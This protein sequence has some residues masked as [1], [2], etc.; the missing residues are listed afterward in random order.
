MREA[1]S[2]DERDAEAEL[3]DVLDD[4]HH[5]QV[6]S[7]RL[8]TEAMSGGYNSTFRGSGVEFDEV[9]EYVDG[10]DPRAVD[11]NVTARFGRLFVKRFVDERELSLLFLLDISASMDGGF[12]AWSLRQFATR[13]CACLSFAAVQNGDNIGLVA[14]HNEVASYLKPKKGVAQA[15]RII[16]TSL[17]LPFQASDC[18]LTTGLDFVARNVRRRTVLFVV[19]DFLSEG[20]EKSMGKNAAKHDVVALRL[21]PPELETLPQGPLRLFDPETGRDFIFDNSNESLRR[22]YQD[23][24]AKWRRGCDAA[25]RR[26]HADVVDLSL[27]RD[28]DP[29]AA[30][31]PILE[32]FRRREMGRGRQ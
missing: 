2:Q 1:K 20:W 28:P 4:V 25:L 30:A 12:A 14:A 15:L 31:K 11:W 9:R 10:D 19:S 5:I 27:P 21:L 24:V 22:S 23:R 16:R 18:A 13:V 6:S 32:F 26:A 17:S 3:A 29:Q 7:H 8:V